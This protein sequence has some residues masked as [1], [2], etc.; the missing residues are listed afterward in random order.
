MSTYTR[1]MTGVRH[2]RKP[3]STAFVV[4]IVLALLA[5]A[6]MAGLT[7]LLRLIAS[8]VGFV[9]CVA[10]GSA[11]AARRSMALTPWA[12]FTAA[13][14]AQGI[15][16]AVDEGTISIGLAVA[17]YTLLAG[18]SVVGL[19]QLKV[20]LTSS[21]EAG[22]PSRV[23]WGAV[24][25]AAGF[26]ASVTIHAALTLSPASQVIVQTGSSTG[27]QWAPSRFDSPTRLG[28]IEDPAITES[29]GLVASR[30]NTD[31]LWTHNDSDDSRL[32]CLH[33][34]GRSCGAVTMTGVSE[35]DWED[36]AAG[37]GIEGTGSGL[38]IGDIGD[39]EATRDSI[40]VYVI[41][42][43]A[44]SADGF[45]LEE[46]PAEALRFRYP[47]RPH[48]AEALTVHP[49]TGDLYIITKDHPARIYRA[50]AP[51]DR[52]IATTLRLVGT[53]SISDTLSD[54]TGA[55]ISS[56]GTRVAISTYAAGFELSLPSSADTGGSGFD[57]I[58]RTELARFSLGSR[59]QG[60]AIAYDLSGD[61]LY[62]TS[63]GLHSPV[64]RVRARP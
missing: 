61:A 24:L 18:G 16:D 42:E 12:L 57:A 38:Y 54:V 3:V 49:E 64:W 9:S 4:A 13:L 47:D 26:F 27:R 53:L 17:Q 32:Y 14:L 15:G 48:N 62:A 31:V 46:V 19:M 7:Y 52:E 59:T 5:A 21:R 37:P 60:E 56:D 8:P 34:S 63:E 11:L 36:I 41:P 40:V 30:V 58:W 6:A 1:I 50:S 23:R 20:E 22:Q 43:P 39:N 51:F 35:R 28:R 44:M 10:I 33:P 29:S 2:T 45:S 55:D 25:L